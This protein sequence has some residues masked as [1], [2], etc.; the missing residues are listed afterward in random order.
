MDKRMTTHRN[1][2]LLG[3]DIGGTKTAVCLGTRD[4]DILAREQFATEGPQPTLERCLALARRLTDSIQRPWADIAA[5]GI[6][7]GGPL[8]SADGLV[9]SPPNLPGWDAVPVVRIIY[10]A[11]GLPTRLENDANAGALAEWRFGAGR[12]ASNLIFLTAGTGMGGGLILDGRL[13]RGR[14]DLA[15]EVGHLRLADDGPMGYGKTGSFE[16]FCSGGGIAALGRSILTNP[17]APSRL[18]TIPPDAL[19]TRDIAQAAAAGDDVARE[20]IR[21]SGRWLGRG[22]ALL[23]DLLNPE[24]I[25]IGSLA[26]RLGPLWLD[27]AMEVV[28]AEA[29][30]PAWQACRIVPAGLGESIGDLAA[31]AVATLAAEA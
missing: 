19:T 8:N 4:G 16:G 29:L 18:D 14:Q 1:T 22:L 9:L 6:S 17:H 28:R 26:L 12:G 24:L 31:L 30:T 21:T 23:I 15:G 7:C 20:I 13:Y 2:L 11:T 10:E 5:A 3:F 27:P 25:V